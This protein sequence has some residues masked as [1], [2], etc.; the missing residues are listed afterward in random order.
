MINREN[1]TI[2]NVLHH[3]IEDSN[4]LVFEQGIKSVEILSKMQ[5]KGIL[6][7]KA[8]DYLNLLFDKAKDTKSQVVKL[9]KT[10]IFTL[11]LTETIGLD[12]FLEQGLLLASTTK[13]QRIRLFILDLFSELIDPQY[14]DEEN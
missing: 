14:I 9:I 8:K 12:Q 1:D 3:M 5:D 6:G 11:F 7:K 13:N 2:Y 4:K 10:A